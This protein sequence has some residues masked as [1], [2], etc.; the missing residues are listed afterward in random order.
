MNYDTL[1]AMK[2]RQKYAEIYGHAC[3]LEYLK[4]H[5]A[6]RI[7]YGAVSGVFSV[8]VLTAAGPDLLSAIFAAGFPA[9]MSYLP[10]YRLNKM[11]KAR[12]QQIMIDFPA[13]ITKLGLLASTGMSLTRAWRRVASEGPADRF[14]YRE[15][16]VTLSEMDSGKPDMK[17]FED[18][19]KRCRISEITRF[20][21]IIIQYRKKGSFELVP[22]LKLHAAECWE[23]R[24]TTVRKLGE[25][26]STKMLIPMI[27]IFIG[28]MLMVISPALL[29]LG[30][31]NVAK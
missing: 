27:L 7:A 6:R 30:G 29:S 25:E 9:I 22:L 12:K 19:A 23:K 11:V 8:I 10:D 5:L 31:L 18:F 21:S 16:R 28:I 1:Y 3:S 13:F 15:L 14:L 4:K 17:A 26:A 24:K 20:V 2:T